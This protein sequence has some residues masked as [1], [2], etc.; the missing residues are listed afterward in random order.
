MRKGKKDYA[1]ITSAHSRYTFTDYRVQGQTIV[2]V[3]GDIGASPLAHAIQHPSMRPVL[4]RCGSDSWPKLWK[5][6]VCLD[7]GLGLSLCAVPLL[8]FR[9]QRSEE[10]GSECRS[11]GVAC[12]TTQK[13]VKGALGNRRSKCTDQRLAMIRSVQ[14]ELMR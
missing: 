11:K 12:E 6:G 10:V 1:S 13:P 9:S 4:S 8:Q 7:V 3:N 2:K 5:L 14:V